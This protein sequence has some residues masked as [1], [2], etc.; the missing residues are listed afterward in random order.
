MYDFYLDKILLPVSPSKLNMMINNQNKTLNLI[1]QGEVNVLKKAGL[2]EIEFS[3]MLP[4]QTYPFSRFKDGYQPPEYYL[5][6]FESLKTSQAPFQFIVTRELATRSFHSTNIQVALEEYEIKESASEGFDIWVDISLKQYVPFG[7]KYCEIT[8]VEE[9]TPE[10]VV[11]EERETTH[12]PEPDVNQ[13][14]TVVKG[15]CLWNIARKY[16]GSGTQYTKIYNANSSIIA[17]PNL[18]YPGQVLT[19]PP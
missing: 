19:I 6:E 17:S 2:T 4:S 16:Y 3:C 13:Y 5:T 9:E 1:H 15:D 10:I 18:I 7:T 14:Y 12:S 11:E 8:F